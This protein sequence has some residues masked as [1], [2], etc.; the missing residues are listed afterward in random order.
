[1]YCRN[2]GKQLVDTA[3]FCMSCGA[4]PRN[5]KSYCVVCGAQPRPEAEI[6]VNCGSRLDGAGE[7]KSWFVALILSIFVGIFGVDRFYLGRVG[8]G[9][10]KLLT[11]GGFYV[12]WLIDIILIATDN[13]K[14]AEGRPLVKSKNL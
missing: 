13:L 2:C 12:W 10:L 6:C 5:G 11:F 14:D 3:E 8:T 7:G 4:R 9:V 1:M